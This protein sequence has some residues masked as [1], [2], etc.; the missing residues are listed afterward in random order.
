[1][2]S[3]LFQSRTVDNTANSP[4]INLKPVNKQE[5]FQEYGLKGRDAV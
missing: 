2:L 3:L 5:I 1:M 4:D